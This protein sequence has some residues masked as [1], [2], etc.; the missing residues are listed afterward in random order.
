M[1]DSIN[2]SVCIDLYSALIGRF[3]PTRNATYA[4]AVTYGGQLSRHRVTFPPYGKQNMEK[5]GMG[6]NPFEQRKPNNP[7]EA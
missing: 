1:I 3:S 2:K 6:K 7:P 5:R 4:R